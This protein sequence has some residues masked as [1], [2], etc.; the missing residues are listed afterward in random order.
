MKE[1]RRR[2]TRP[3]AWARHY[4]D[5]WHAKAGDPRLPRWL[6]VACL[7]YGAHGNNGHAPFRR[8]EVAL[9]LGSPPDHEGG[10]G[11]LDRRRVHE[12][13]KTA[14][15]YGWLAPGSWARCLIVPSD[16]IKKGPFD[17][18]VAPCPHHGGDDR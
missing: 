13:I 14:V 5:E 9:V 10:P 3:D 16:Q 7:A 8:G 4:Q 15:E 18:A 12:V 6:R 11:P 1:R 2:Q 17:Q